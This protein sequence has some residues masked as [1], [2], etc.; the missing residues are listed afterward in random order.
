MPP[1][2]PGG[3]LVSTT[4]DGKCQL[5]RTGVQEYANVCRGPKLLVR[6]TRSGAIEHEGKPAATQGELEALFRG[7]LEKE[8]SVRLV[9]EAGSGAPSDRIVRVTSAAGNARISRVSLLDIPP[10]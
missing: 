8:P 5:Y 7:A 1:P 6:V 4:P 3:K 10:P 2:P 9:I